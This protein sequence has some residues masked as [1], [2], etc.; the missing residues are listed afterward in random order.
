MLFAVNV[1]VVRSKY[2]FAANCSVG[3]VD[4][5]VPFNLVTKAA[6]PLYSVIT[7]TAGVVE[8][9]A[10]VT[11]LNANRGAQGWAMHLPEA[12]QFATMFGVTTTGA[13]RLASGMI[14][15]PIAMTAL[16]KRGAGPVDRQPVL[17]ELANGVIVPPLTQTTC[18]LAGTDASWLTPED[19]PEVDNTGILRSGNDKKSGGAAP[20]AG[21]KPSTQS[22]VPAAVAL[23]SAAF[24]LVVSTI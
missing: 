2:P 17:L 7:V 24:A 16:A 21:V 13:P 23:K 15:G 4:E 9:A 6:K 12:M 3:C 10:V 22:E 5:I 8:V 1:L 20:N 19:L 14:S 18:R 11:V